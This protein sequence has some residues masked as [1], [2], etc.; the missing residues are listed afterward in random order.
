MYPEDILLCITRICSDYVN[1]VPELC[2]KLFVE[3]EGKKTLSVNIDEIPPVDGKDKW[4]S[5]I[6]K[7]NDLVKSTVKDDSFMK[8]MTCD[9]STSTYVDKICSMIQIMDTTK[10]YL[11]F[12]CRAMCGIPSVKLYGSYEDWVQLKVQCENLSNFF[13]D[14]VKEY[15]DSKIIPILDNLIE[16]RRADPDPEWWGHIANKDTIYGSGISFK[17]N[18]WATHLFPSVNLDPFF[19]RKEEEKQKVI[20]GF[21]NLSGISSGVTDVPVTFKNNGT[22]LNFKICSGFQGVHQNEDGSLEAIKGYYMKLV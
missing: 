9:F 16:T 15:L 18:G 13:G 10:S 2:R 3:H 19:D 11:A 12:E 7:W 21:F 14:E 5:V 4:D 17:W 22:D 1:E 8:N 6:E 20:I